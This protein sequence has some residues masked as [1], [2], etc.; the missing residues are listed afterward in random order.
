[1]KLVA[2]IILFILLILTPASQ[3]QTKSEFAKKVYNSVVLLYSQT[4]DGGMKMRCTATS[5][6]TVAHPDKTEYTRFVSAAHC[7]DGDRDEEQK[8]QKYFITADNEGEKVFLPAKLIEAG[9]KK[10][11]DDFSIFE[12]IGTKFSTIP[13]GDSSKLYMGESLI[14]VSSPF[15]LGKLYYEGYMSNLHVDRPPMDAGEV[16]WTDVMIAQIGGGPGSSGSSVVSLDQHA[17][18]G[19]IVGSFGQ[20][21]PGMILVPVDKFKAFESAVDAGKYKKLSPVDTNSLHF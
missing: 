3:A 5:Y 11:G 9:D 20:G 1:M 7:V 14:G 17:I 19:F 10:R 13:I 12:V 4:D 18:I 8:L 15:G 2:P 6:K 21:N 16:Q